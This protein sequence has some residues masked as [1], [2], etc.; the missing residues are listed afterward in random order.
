MGTSSLHWLSTPIEID[1]TYPFRTAACLYS[2]IQ[3]SL[4]AEVISEY[5]R[6]ALYLS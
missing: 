4:F 2:G 3:G 6:P 5:Q 1:P